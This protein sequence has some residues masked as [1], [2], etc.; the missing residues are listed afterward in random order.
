MQIT[1]QDIDHIYKF[2]PNLTP[3]GLAKVIALRIRHS[4]H[5]FKLTWTDIIEHRWLTHW[6]WGDEGHCIWV[7]KLVQLAYGYMH[8]DP[9][10]KA[11][12]SACLWQDYSLNLQLAY[13][14]Q[15]A[16]DKLRS[17]KY[18]YWYGDLEGE[19]ALA[20]MDA[21]EAVVRDV[22]G[23]AIAAGVSVWHA[24]GAFAVDMYAVLKFH[25]EH[26]DTSLYSM[27][28]EMHSGE[29]ARFEEHFDYLM[30]EHLFEM[31]PCTFDSD[32]ADSLYDVGDLY[33]PDTPCYVRVAALEA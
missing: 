25:A 15:L 22:V 7:R 3:E 11:T 32:L 17:N 33:C 29:V 5:F 19:V 9:V 27:L 14:A 12:F 26:V 20:V 10:Q 1:G 28:A 8:W 2:R 18:P 30:Y 24:Y 4:V 13:K 23:T 6:A 21:A 31:F 16:E